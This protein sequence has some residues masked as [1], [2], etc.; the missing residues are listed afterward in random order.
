VDF[1]AIENKIEDFIADKVRG[2]GAK[3]VILGLSGGID[4][5][6][7]AALSARAI[8]AKNVLALIMPSPVN[9]K[10]DVD[11]AK[12]L[13]SELGIRI[14]IIPIKDIMKSFSASLKPDSKAEGNLMARVRMSLL[15]YNANHLN[16]LVVGTGNK[17]ELSVGY[18]TKYGDGGCDMLP[19]GDLLKTEVYELARS[20]KIP[21]K[22]INK[23]PSAGLWAGQTDEAEL[24]VTYEELDSVLS[25]KKGIYFK[26]QRMVNSAEHK[27]RAPEVCKI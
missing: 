14:E 3:G 12:A 27:R 16:Y 26:I 17:S 1:L 15:Y 13:A 24:G 7:V 11:D 2:A 8:G 9:K 10:S 25:G 18:F 23:A 5:A 4:S 22:I 6:V 20:L 19:I 21:E